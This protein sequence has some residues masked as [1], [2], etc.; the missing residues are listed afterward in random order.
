MNVTCKHLSYLLILCGL[1]TNRACA[2]TYSEEQEGIGGEHS[3]IAHRNEAY[4]SLLAIYSYGYHLFTG[5]GERRVCVPNEMV[6]EGHETLCRMERMNTSPPQHRAENAEGSLPIVALISRQMT[7]TFRRTV[8]ETM[9]GLAGRR[10]ECAV[11]L[12]DIFSNPRFRET[13]FLLAAADAFRCGWLSKMILDESEDFARDTDFYMVA[14]RYMEGQPS[15]EDEGRVRRA[16]EADRMYNAHA[17]TQVFV[18]NLILT[19][20]IGQFMGIQEKF[21][22]I[23][24]DNFGLFI[25]E[26]LI[27]GIIHLLNTTTS[28]QESADKYEWKRRDIRVL[29]NTYNG[30]ILVRIMPFEVFRDHLAS[31]LEVDGDNPRWIQMVFTA[32]RKE[33]R[34]E[35]LGSKIT[36]MVNK[37]VRR[38]IELV[39]AGNTVELYNFLMDGDNIRYVCEKS[40]LEW[41]IWGETHGFDASIFQAAIGAIRAKGKRVG[42]VLEQTVGIFF[43][44][45]ND[46][47]KLDEIRECGIKFNISVGGVIVCVR[48]VD[49]FKQGNEPMGLLNFRHDFGVLGH[50]YRHSLR[51]LLDEIKSNFRDKGNFDAY[52]AFLHQA[53]KRSGMIPDTEYE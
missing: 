25:D 34:D 24:S 21:S 4:W 37:N 18:A 41:L 23:T 15:D 52:L 44:L 30:Y 47:D 1:F 46:Q 14:R 11:C 2:S 12:R 28:I 16:L 43:L 19:G 13:R 8:F 33:S 53:F 38:F 22:V 48:S 31:F 29:S 36:N 5:H 32:M 9:A 6:M 39:R 42:I 20:R 51:Q 49:H 27:C 26:E 35:A 10:E 3:G 7:D 40:V 17:G 50:L 45:H